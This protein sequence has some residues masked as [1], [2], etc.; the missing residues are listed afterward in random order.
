MKYCSVVIPVFNE[1]KN[2]LPVFNEIVSYFSPEN[3]YE[4]RL[5]EMI[6]VNDGSQ[7]STLE[8]INKLKRQ[9]EFVKV[10]SISHLGFGETL[11]KG[12]RAARFELIIYMDGDGQFHF[13]ECFPIL[14]NKI[15]QSSYFIISGKRFRR[16]DPFSRRILSF[17]GNNLLRLVNLNVT[18]I[19][20]GFKIYSKTLLDQIEINSKTFFIHTE[21]YAQTI[22]KEGLIKEIEIPHYRRR[23]GKSHILSL[24][25][26][27]QAATECIKFFRNL[28]FNLV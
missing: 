25:I 24:K 1:E 20:C 4:Y 7:D 2:V 26:F 18:D 11:A 15:P 10:V 9:Y 14:I 5:K 12:L 28:G 27:I 6:W 22:K 19:D 16:K 13:D 3:K 17:I 21:I 8:C 23:E